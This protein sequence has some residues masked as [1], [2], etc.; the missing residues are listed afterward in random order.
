MLWFEPF[1]EIVAAALAVGVLS[2]LSL[3]LWAQQR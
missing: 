3:T 2:L 1:I